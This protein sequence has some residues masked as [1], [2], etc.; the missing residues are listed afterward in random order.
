MRDL[1]DDRDD[2]GR[3]VGTV[4]YMAPEQAGGE[5][6]GPAADWYALGA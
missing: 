3:L 6:V 1:A 4:N 5:N 2:D